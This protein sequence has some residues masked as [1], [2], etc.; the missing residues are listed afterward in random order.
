V[1]V[2]VTGRNDG[3]TVVSDA[4]VAISGAAAVV[5]NVLANDSDIDGDAISVSAVRNL[6]GNVG[7]PVNG[8]Y[9]TLVLNADG[10]YTYSV[11]PALAAV[12]NLAPGATAIDSFTYT[13]RDANNAV[14]TTTLAVTVVGTNDGP[15]AV[16]DARTIQ[17]DAAVLTTSGTAL[18]N[19]TDPD[20]GILS[21]VSVNGVTA[22]VAASVS[23]T[24][25][26]LTMGA[27][28]AYTYAL[29]NASTAVQELRVGQS[30][31]D[32]FSY[33]ISDGQGGEATAS[34]IVTVTGRNDAPT[35]VAQATG[36]TTEDITTVTSGSSSHCPTTTPTCRAR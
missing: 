7:G 5:G 15:R 19:D 34:V 33:T 17:E 28:G 26:S 10:S 12:S 21:V 9:G 8:T 11:N 3:P 29:N 1:V 24:Y 16:N 35:V 31:T 32:T 30:V 4:N 2:T 14:A 18:S 6:A 20:G 25:G 36:A 27:D 22:N 13:V 23:G